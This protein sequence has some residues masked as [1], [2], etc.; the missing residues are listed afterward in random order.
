MFAGKLCALCAS[1]TS[2]A[3][4]EQRG[5]PMSLQGGPKMDE[6]AVSLSNALTDNNNKIYLLQ[7]VE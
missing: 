1:D 5:W 6:K 4:E 2:F 7:F 3:A